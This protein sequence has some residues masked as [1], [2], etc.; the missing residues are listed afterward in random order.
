VAG[1]VVV[2]IGTLVYDVVDDKLIATVQR[3]LS[4]PP[5]PGAPGTPG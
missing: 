1:T 2:W 3:H 4:T 5:L